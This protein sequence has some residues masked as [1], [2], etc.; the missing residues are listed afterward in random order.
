M[1]HTL[2]I[3]DKV[4]DDLGNSGKICLILHT[5][6]CPRKLSQYTK[7]ERKIKATGIAFSLQDFDS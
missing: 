6:V 5:S 1:L 4:S 7:M 2:T 3:Y